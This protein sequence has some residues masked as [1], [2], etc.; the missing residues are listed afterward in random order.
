MNYRL[1]LASII[2]SFL[3][4]CET[5][6][7]RA[8]I[9]EDHYRFENFVQNVEPKHEYIFMACHRHKPTGWNVAKQYPAG[10]Q[11]LW[12][13]AAKYTTT[14]SNVPRVAYF[15]LQTNLEA[16]KSYMPNRKIE[17]NKIALWIQEVESG[18]RV[19][20][21]LEAELKFPVAETIVSHKQCKTSSV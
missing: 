21:I 16:G 19:T 6:P 14:T 9:K 17:G 8:E 3:L 13:K 18:E 7:I 11:N 1:L 12:I 4:G 20:E 2:S 10:P 15:N 5:L